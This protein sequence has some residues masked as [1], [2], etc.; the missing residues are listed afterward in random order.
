[1]AAILS[2]HPKINLQGSVIDWDKSKPEEG[3]YDFEE[4]VY[5]NYKRQ[6][7]R[8]DHWLIWVRNY[9]ERPE[10]DEFRYLKSSGYQ[11]V[12]VEDKLYWPEG[13]TPNENG[14]YTI[15]DL[16]LMQ[17]PLLSYV[18]EQ[19]E[20]EA[21]TTKGGRAKLEE[22]ESQIARDGG[23]L[24]PEVADKFFGEREKKPPIEAKRI[25]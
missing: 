12:R 25:Y 14:Y 21:L 18:R 17:Y 24:P 8:P 1:M 10:F 3:M 4:K 16:I 7:S 6:Q 9:P 23:A 15:G 22:I 5:I 2:K 19:V 11:P 13:L 20:A